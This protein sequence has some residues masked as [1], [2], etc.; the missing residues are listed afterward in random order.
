MNQL[1]GSVSQRLGQC[2]DA[3]ELRATVEAACAALGEVINVTLVCGNDNPD[4]KLCVIDLVLD[5]TDIQA[6]AEEI[7]G[8][9]F[10]YSSVIIDIVPHPDF[11]C[12]RG[13]T[14]DVPGCSCIPKT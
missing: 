14:D 1:A 10:G 3:A 13:M 7:G 6:C 9:V 8:R 4:K 12:P 5:R 11:R 2:L